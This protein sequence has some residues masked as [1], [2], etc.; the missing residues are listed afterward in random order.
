MTRRTGVEVEFS[1][2]RSSITPSVP[3]SATAFFVGITERGP[4]DEAILVQSPVDFARKCGGR[5]ANTT[6]VDPVTAFFREGGRR[7]YV[8]R[9]AGSVPVKASAMLKDRS[10]TP[11]LNTIKLE[12]TSAGAWGNN[13]TAVVEDGT[14]ASTVKITIKLSGVT[15]DTRNNMATTTAIVTAF[16]TSRWVRAI[17]QDSVTAA[18]NDLPKLTG[19]AAF[20]GGDD[21][22]DTVTDETK[23]LTALDLF[24]EDLG[25]GVVVIPGQDIEDVA[26]GLATHCTTVGTERIALASAP[27]GT[28]KDT[29]I[30]TGTS[31]L[32]V[33][34]KSVGMVW[35]WLGFREGTVERWVDP[36]AIAAGQRARA[37][38]AGAWNAPSAHP[39]RDAK[40]VSLIEVNVTKADVNDLGEAGVNAYQRRSGIIMLRNWWSLTEDPDFP[41]LSTYDCLATIASDLR[42]TLDREGVWQVIDGGEWAASKAEGLCSSYLQQWADNGGLFPESGDKGYTADFIVTPELLVNEQAEMSIGVRLSH[43]AALITLRINSVGPGTPL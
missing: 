14:Q 36:A 32:E 2:T 25:P 28:D 26:S 42:T 6:L 5:T 24:D 37:Q 27:Y 30:S 34:G 35:P 16:S 23:Y 15:V 4:L 40:F 1:T 11:G 29:A 22:L 41:T 31:M 33:G 39:Y 21:D 43:H 7:L 9:V 18:P 20:S 10:T 38:L 12:A 3:G 17:D 19:S 8:A 13:L